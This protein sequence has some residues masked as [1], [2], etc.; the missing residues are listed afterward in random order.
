MIFSDRNKDRYPGNRLWDGDPFVRF[1]KRDQLKL[2][3]M[4]GKSRNGDVVPIV[5]AC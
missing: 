1:M 3:T 2:V 5:F 4:N